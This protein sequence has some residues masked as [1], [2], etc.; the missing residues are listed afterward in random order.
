M[1]HAKH[2]APCLQLHVAQHI[3]VIIIV[4]IAFMIFWL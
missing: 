2:L 4:V 1:M 3:I